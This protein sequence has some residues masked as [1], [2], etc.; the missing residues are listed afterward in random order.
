MSD[1]LAARKGETGI[2]RKVTFYLLKDYKALLDYDRGTTYFRKNK[3][4][5]QEFE[6]WRAILELPSRPL[7]SWLAFC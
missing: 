4:P 2:F 1:Y 5:V 3:P 7:L 6:P